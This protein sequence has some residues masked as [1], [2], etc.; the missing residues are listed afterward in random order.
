MI[1]DYNSQD[2]TVCLIPQSKTAVSAF[3]ATFFE[4]KESV[5][6]SRVF[7][8]VIAPVGAL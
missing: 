7:F 4:G 6:V 1:P 5:F 3:L 8:P 2:A